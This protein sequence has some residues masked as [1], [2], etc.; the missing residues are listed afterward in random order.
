[1]YKVNWI[2][3]IE[4]A[5]SVD[6]AAIGAYFAMQRRASLAGVFTVRDPGG[7]EQTVDVIERMQ[8]D[9][10]FE[11]SMWRRDAIERSC[12]LLA[13]RADGYPT[14]YGPY[15]DVRSRMVAVGELR[16]RHGTEMKLFR[17]ELSPLSF[18]VRPL[19]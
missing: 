8:T 12:Y 17:V 7:R 2:I 1:M 5:T 4:D 10:E 14:V 15:D 18:E 13:V 9:Q 19:G 16:E 3:D 11:R 6:E